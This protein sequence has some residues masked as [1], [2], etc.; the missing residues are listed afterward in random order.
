MAHLA[1]LSGSSC[2]RSRSSK[3]NLA[4]HGF[5]HE[6]KECRES[7]ISTLH[8]AVQCS[9][10]YRYIALCTPAPAVR[11]RAEWRDGGESMKPEAASLYLEPHPGAG[12][13]SPAAPARA[14]PQASL[15]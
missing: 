11:L 7:R 6:C 9:A 1:N 12:Q 5:P 3:A 14:K 4:T 13:A 2:R 8:G 10:I 15:S